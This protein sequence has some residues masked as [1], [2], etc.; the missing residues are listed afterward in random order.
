MINLG[1][2][3]YQI[4]GAITRFYYGK[5]M[6]FKS[7][8]SIIGLSGTNILSCTSLIRLKDG[9]NPD[10]MMDTAQSEPGIGNIGSGQGICIQLSV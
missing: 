6:G 4:H 1:E 5:V 9:N 8:Y 7:Y 3:Y 2:Q 10:P